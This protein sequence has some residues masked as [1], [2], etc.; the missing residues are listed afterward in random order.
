[1]GSSPF[2]AAPATSGSSV[3]PRGFQHSFPGVEMQ[4]PAPP[5]LSPYPAHQGNYG[6][7][8]PVA[9]SPFAPHQGGYVPPP[10][11]AAPLGVQPIQQPGYGP[12]IG[13]VQG[14][15]EDFSSLS[16]QTRPG[17]MELSIDAKE[18][19]RPLEGDV[20]PKSLA[21]MYPMNCDP[22]YLRL[23]TSAIP[24]SQSLASRWHLP[25]GAVVCP[26]AEPPDGVS[27]LFFHV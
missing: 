17:L 27:A 5:T 8:P 23:T 9:P 22:R 14:L 10:L 12:P 2:N 18:L 13:A 15:T 19:P 3:P 26:L 16:I 1:M 24:S 21:E 25:L 6:P 4:A 7:V 11:V 20:E